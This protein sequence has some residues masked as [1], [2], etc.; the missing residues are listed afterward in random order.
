MYRKVSAKN[1]IRTVNVKGESIVKGSKCTMEKMSPRPRT[2]TPT[3]FLI[4]FIIFFILFLR[5]CCWG[6]PDIL[7]DQDSLVWST[8]LLLI[9]IDYVSF[10]DM[11]TVWSPLLSLL[12]VAS[13]F[14][15]HF[16]YESISSFIPN[17]PIWWRAHRTVTIV[18]VPTSFS[19]SFPFD[20]FVSYAF[21]D[22]AMD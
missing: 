4:L 7:M 16:I 10:S 13:L 22:I 8:S 19:P 21:P 2:V 11:N 9:V 15:P 17:L 1:M 18:E 14:H 3:H 5:L 20:D 6:L 12:M